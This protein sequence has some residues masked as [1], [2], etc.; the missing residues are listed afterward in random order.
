[1]KPQ[2]VTSPKQHL[3]SHQVIYDGGEDEWS[4]AKILWRDDWNEATTTGIGI[5]W[6]GKDDGLGQPQSSGH[7]TW[8]VLPEGFISHCVEMWAT[9]LAR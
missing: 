5:R 9:Y 1:M 7:P 8:F 2:D 3:A 6:N 4:V